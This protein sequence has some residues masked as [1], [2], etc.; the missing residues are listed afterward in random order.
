LFVEA[1]GFG[2]GEVLVGEVGERLPAPQREP[3]RER[4]GGAGVFACSQGA[5]SF[6]SETLEAAPVEV[7]GVDLDRIPGGLGHHQAPRLVG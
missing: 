3:V 4:V 6:A 1:G 5:A 7:L 2:G